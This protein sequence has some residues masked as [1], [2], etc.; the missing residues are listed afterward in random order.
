MKIVI[1]EDD[2]F[3]LRA[4][5]DKF[6][7]EGYEVTEASNGEEALLKVKEVKPDI[8]LLDLVMPKKNGFDVLA[9][10][11]LDDTIS[12]IP[13]LVLSNLGQDSDVKKAKDLGAVD[14]YIK[15]NSPIA[16]VVEKVKHFI[17]KEK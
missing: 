16:G 10:M 12:K 4:L 3:I 14:F 6:K 11:K 5:V 8:M 1:A 9:E 7:R 13:V 15:S 17:A 2:K